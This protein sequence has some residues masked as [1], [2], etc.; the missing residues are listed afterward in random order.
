VL[1][2][3]HEP[4]QDLTELFEDSCFLVK[5]RSCDSIFAFMFV[6]AS[7]NRK[8]PDWWATGKCLRRRI[9]TPCSGTVC[10]CLSTLR[11]I[12][13]RTPSSVQFYIFDGDM[14]A[15]VNMQCSVVD[16]LDR[17]VVAAM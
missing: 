2:P 8:C 5:I 11:P 13:S 9:H 15:Q 6:G 4:S 3:L 14:E 10:C 12:E 17:E 1:A 7:P 16:G